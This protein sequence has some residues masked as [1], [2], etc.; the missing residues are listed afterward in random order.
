LDR[1]RALLK[2][3]AMPEPQLPPYDEASVEHFPHEDEIRRAV[4]VHRKLTKT[5]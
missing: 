4:A 2:E 1:C 5:A 3:L